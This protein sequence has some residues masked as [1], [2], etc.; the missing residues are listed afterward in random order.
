M[1]FDERQLI[2]LIC[3]HV[4]HV[5]A[6][7]ACVQHPATVTRTDLSAAAAERVRRSQLRK[8]NPA[9]ASATSSPRSATADLRAI[10]T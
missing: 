2:R 5:A 3:V 8:Y 9:A 4:S 6:T 10:A 1:S 7:Y